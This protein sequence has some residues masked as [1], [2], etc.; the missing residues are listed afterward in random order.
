M[1]LRGTVRSSEAYVAVGV[2]GS[3]DDGVGSV[4]DFGGEDGRRGRGRGGC[5]VVLC[6]WTMDES[7]VEWAA[8]SEKQWPGRFDLSEAKPLS[9]VWMWRAMSSLGHLISLLACR[10]ANECWRRCGLQ[11]REDRNGRAGG[12][13]GRVE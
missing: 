2:A 9:R 7:E 3:D 4:E 13:R 1:R 11:L 6:H 8:A 5:G 12:G 10:A